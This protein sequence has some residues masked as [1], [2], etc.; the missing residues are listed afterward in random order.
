MNNKTNCKDVAGEMKEKMNGNGYTFHKISNGG[1]HIAKSAPLAADT[2]GITQT[3][4][5]LNGF[6][7]SELVVVDAYLIEKPFQSYVKRKYNYSIL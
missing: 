5:L 6:S 7:L 2:T 3:S 1:G 4:S